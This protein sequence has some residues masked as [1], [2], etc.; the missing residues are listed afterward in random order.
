MP[1]IGETLREARMRQ[2]LDIADVESRTKIRA[3]YLRALENEEWSLLPGPTFVKTFLR[4]YA[5]V[6]G[7]DPHL[8]VEEYR[9][10]HEPRDDADFQ[11]LAPLPRD[12]RRGPR[13]APGG[14]GPSPGLIAAVVVGAAL[15]FLLVLGLL[16]GEDSGDPDRTS[17]S[18][19]TTQ[20][21]TATT[22]RRRPAPPQGVNVRVDPAEPTYLCVDT[23][24]G[25][26][27]VFEDTLSAP[28]TFRNPNRLRM[29][30]GKRSISLT[31]NGRP[32]EIADSAEPLGIAF[33]RNGSTELP[34]GNRPCA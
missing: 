9:V 10:N 6:V 15:A 25:T 27:V 8:L 14:G 26:A 19:T 16:G 30:L 33:T 28:R 13:R 2:R 34:A 23:G 31:A 7:V 12:S 29:N 17:L 5:E 1:P 32:I 20:P 24:P 3:K 11:P 22:E 18:T 4:T 21:R